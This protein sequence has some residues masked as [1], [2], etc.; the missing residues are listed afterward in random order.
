MSHTNF[1]KYVL[2]YLSLIILT[3]K[4]DGLRNVGILLR[5]DEVD[6]HR[7]LHLVAQIIY[8]DFLK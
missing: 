6:L 8:H 4:T 2:Y 1:L 5:I 7:R 3:M